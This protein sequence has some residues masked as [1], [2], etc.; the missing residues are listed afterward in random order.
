MAKRYDPFAEKPRRGAPSIYTPELA[1]EICKRLRGGRSLYSVCEDADMPNRSTVFDWLHDRDDFAD[2][3][4]RAKVASADAD[5][6]KGER[7]T[8]AVSEGRLDPNAGRV[9][10]DG[11]KW[12]SAH[13]Q[14]KRF[15]VQRHTVGGEGGGAI[16]LRFESLS[17][18]QLAQFIARLDHA[19]ES[20]PSDDSAGEGGGG[21]GTGETPQGG[22]V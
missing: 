22:D 20:G 19:A 10:L 6:E 12:T 11:V 17:D 8:E 7:I 15:G 9:A 21:G 2:Q 18:A 16:P 3:Y 13:K 5:A 14:P 1:A 4:A